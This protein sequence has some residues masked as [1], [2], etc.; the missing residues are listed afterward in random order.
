MNCICNVPAVTRTVQKLGENHGKQFFTCGKSSTCNFFCWAGANANSFSIKQQIPRPVKQS[1][2]TRR[3]GITVSIKILLHHI[4]AFPSKKIWFSAIT[5]GTNP[6]LIKFYLSIPESK[7]KYKDNLRIWTFDFEIYEHFVSTL[8]SSEYSPFVEVTELPRFLSIGLKRYL[9]SM[10]MQLVDVELNIGSYMRDTLLPFQVEGIKFIIQHGG[11]GMIADEMGCGKTLQAIAILQHYSQYW[12]ALILVPPNLVTQWR[13]ELATYASDVISES[14]ICVVKK[15]SDSVCGKIMLVPY[16]LLDKLAEKEKIRPEQ[17][18]V[19][20]CDESHNLKSKDAKRT[21]MAL[22]FL[23]AAN[24][25]VCLSGTPATNRPEELFTQLSGLRPDIFSDYDQFTVRYC[26]AKAGRFGWETKGSSNES[27]LK[28]LLEGCVMIRRLKSDVVKNLPTKKREVRYIAADPVLLEELQKKQKEAKVIDAAL[29]DPHNDAAACKHFKAQQQVLLNAQ[30]C[31]T[32]M[33]K[34]SGVLDELTKLIEEAR[35]E[36]AIAEE[37]DDR[38][39]QTTS[40]SLEPVEETYESFDFSDHDD[41]DNDD[42]VSVAIHEPINLVKTKI[43]SS[44]KRKKTIPCPDNDNDNDNDNVYNKVTAHSLSLEKD[45]ILVLEECPIPTKSAIKKQETM[46]ENVRPPNDIV[47]LEGA[48]LVDS[49]DD[50]NNN[51]SNGNIG[52]NGSN[53]DV[54]VSPSRKRLRRMCEAKTNT[55]PPAP[56]VEQD[57]SAD[58]RRRSSRRRKGNEEKVQ[59]HPI[60]DL[61]E[62]VKNDDNGNDDELDDVF[63]MDRNIN[64]QGN[65]GTTSTSTNRHVNHKSKKRTVQVD[66]RDTAC[67]Y[68]GLGRKIIVFAHHAAVLNALESCLR[69]LSVLFIRIDG[70]VPAAT[71]GALIKKFQEDDETDVAL[72]SLA[73]CGTGLNLTRANVALFAELAWSAGLILQAEDRIHRIGQSSKDVRIVYLIAKGTADDIVWEQ[74]Q[75]KHHM[76]DSTVGIADRSLISNQTGNHY[77]LPFSSTNSSDIQSQSRSTTGPLDTFMVVSLSEDVTPASSESTTVSVDHIST[78]SVLQP[79]PPP[80]EFP[81]RSPMKTQTQ[82]QTHL[83]FP[84]VPKK[85]VITPSK[86]KICSVL[87]VWGPPKPLSV[88]VDISRKNTNT[89]QVP[90]HPPDEIESQNSDMQS[91]VEKSATMTAANRF[92]NN[93]SKTSTEICSEKSPGK[94]TT[95]PSQ[96]VDDLRHNVKSEDHNPTPAVTSPVSIQQQESSRSPSHQP[97]STRPQIINPSTNQQHTTSS[98]NPPYQTTQQA[99]PQLT[100]PSVNQQHTTSSY[101]PPYQTTQQARPQ[102]TGPSVNQQHTTS[103]YNPPY[104][105]TQQA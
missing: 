99:R 96:H 73:A 66:V 39:G 56:A 30:Y 70:Q 14:D 95:F 103:S 87:P 102:L 16:S 81:K 69:K 98:Y 3:A 91:S 7:R 93:I 53:C 52:D 88:A 15:S 74:I 33:S 34:I 9:A 6:A 23:R 8:L 13:G 32:G 71:R 36:R 43:K 100:G 62:E 1:S 55:S 79:A 104:Q 42:D 60:T 20:I 61:T 28:S 90:V 86:P 72:L 29:R 21:G 18:G 38:K 45:D 44:L 105:T 75:K 89:V 59:S 68:R 78:S 50:N 57:P 58:G 47:D 35:V 25:A 92:S 41:D 80:A 51:N 40:S 17:F 77:S 97:Y 49:D 31:I 37:A 67:R 19:V 94:A 54:L 46:K 24:V 48:A 5:I 26:D 85:T 10:P 64:V 101:N 4:E 2:P 27:E 63:F 12:P 82:T 84:I 11:R 76:L 83:N 65:T 22:P